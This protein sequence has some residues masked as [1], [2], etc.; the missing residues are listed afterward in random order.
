MTWVFHALRRGFRLIMSAILVVG[1]AAASMGGAHA[2]AAEKTRVMML[3]DIGS[4]PDAMES[5]VR[6][7]LYTN[8]FDVEGLLAVTSRHLRDAVHPEQIAMRVRA[9]GEVLPNLRAHAKGYPEEKFLRDRIKSGRPEFGMA[10]VGRG[11]DSEASEWIVAAV[12]KPDPRPVWSSLWGGAVD[13]AQALWK[14]FCCRK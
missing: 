3:T 4:D 2:E 10:G 11:K 1:C 9:Y 6:F 5:M 7:L 14:G 13:L 8:E 12:D